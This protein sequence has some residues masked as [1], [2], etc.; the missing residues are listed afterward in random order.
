MDFPNQELGKYRW[1]QLGVSRRD[2]H[3]EEPK[4]GLFA[5]ALH[6]EMRKCGTGTRVLPKISFL[7]LFA[8]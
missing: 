7:I 8:E 6:G 5:E 3:A 4:N 1:H 2:T